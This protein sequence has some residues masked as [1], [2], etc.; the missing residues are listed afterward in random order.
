MRN[1]AFRVK[2]KVPSFFG[3]DL[4][5]VLYYFVMVIVILIV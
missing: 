5:A 3:W 1:D 4:V 2:S